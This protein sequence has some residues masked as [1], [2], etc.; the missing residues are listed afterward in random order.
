MRK[1]KAETVETRQRIIKAAGAEFRR[2]GI[3][4]TGVAELMAAAGLTHG[5]FYRH[6]ASKDQ[7]VAEVCAEGMDAGIEIIEAAASDPQA[8]NG[9]EEIAENYLSTEH[10]DDRSGG[11][12]FASL[13]CELARADEETR[14]AASDGFLKRVDLIAKQ[15]RRTKPDIARARAMFVLSS[16]VGTLI[17]SRIVDDP[18]LSATILQ[19]A[20]KHLIEL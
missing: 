19:E 9:L 8:L 14:A 7:L 15:Y 5:G 1:S 6:F 4:A 16:M 13:G 17:M 3:H 2:N 12:P 11:C 18:K 10:R 20:K